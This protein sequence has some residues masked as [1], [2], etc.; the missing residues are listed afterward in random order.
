MVWRAGG[1]TGHPRGKHRRSQT[2]EEWTRAVVADTGASMVEWLISAVIARIAR[3]A[4][5][6]PSNRLEDASVRRRRAP[7]SHASHLVYDD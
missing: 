3:P 1:E 6:E 4:P 5:T 7:A 2:V